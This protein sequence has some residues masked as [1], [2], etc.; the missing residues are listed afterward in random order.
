[1]KQILP[2]YIP[3][4]L[5]YNTKLLAP[6]IS[7]GSTAVSLWTIDEVHTAV[8]SA[9]LP[10]LRPLVQ[11][12]TPIFTSINSTIKSIE[13]SG[14]AATSSDESYMLSQK[15]RDVFQRLSDSTDGHMGA[16][17]PAKSKFVSA[18]VMQVDPERGDGF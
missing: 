4:P 12:T 6:H 1:M 2:V 14:H 9:C 3:C 15:E 8:I 16:R 18:T 5:H 7:Q 17:E 11:Y 13:F 10:S